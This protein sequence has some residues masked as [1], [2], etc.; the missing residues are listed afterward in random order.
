[1]HNKVDCYMKQLKCQLSLTVGA[2]YHE[3]QLTVN[4]QITSLRNTAKKLYNLLATSDH[5]HTTQ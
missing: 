2:L 3:L 1:M 4:I 5:S